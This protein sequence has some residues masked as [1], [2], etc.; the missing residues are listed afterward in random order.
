MI[1]RI[2]HVV[3]TARTRPRSPRSTRRCWGCRWRIRT[4][5]RQVTPSA[6]SAARGGHRRF[7]RPLT[8]AEIRPQT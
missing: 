3:S 6:L 2:H 7:P 8:Q 5:T 1:G 4:T